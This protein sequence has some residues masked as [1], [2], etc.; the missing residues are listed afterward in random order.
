MRTG[1]NTYRAP[2]RGEDKRKAA[3]LILERKKLEV[4]SVSFIK[5]KPGN[6]GNVVGFSILFVN[7]DTAINQSV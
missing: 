3:I 2:K 7:K 6:G 4:I 5:S 1:N